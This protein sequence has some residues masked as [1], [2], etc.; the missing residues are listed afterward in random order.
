MNLASPEACVCSSIRKTARAVTQLYDKAL[1]PAGLRSTQFNILATLHGHKA[2][3]LALLGKELVLDQTTLTRSLDLLES[4]GLVER[5]PGGSLR[6]RSMQLTVS[7]RRKFEQALPLWRGAQASL[8]SCIGT[9]R[10]Y[11]LLTELEGITVAAQ[12]S[13]A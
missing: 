4:Q 1:R 6:D 7:G 10:W 3:N 5:V 11:A 13:H 12:G 9:R 8:L 2:A